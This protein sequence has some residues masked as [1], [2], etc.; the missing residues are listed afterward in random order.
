MGKQRPPRQKKRTETQTPKITARLLERPRT[1]RWW[2]GQDI[3]YPVPV[4][5]RPAI[6]D[7]L[8]AVLYED[9]LYWV[10]ANFDYT[11]VG[12]IT[13]DAVPATTS[14]PRWFGAAKIAASVIDWD[15]STRAVFV[16]TRHKASRSVVL[17]EGEPWRSGNLF[18]D[19]GAV[20]PLAANDRA[21]VVDCYGCLVDSSNRRGTIGEGVRI[22]SAPSLDSDGNIV[23]VVSTDDEVYVQ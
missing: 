21:V 5:A 9:C 4:Y 17:S 13:L 16:D 23:T 10:D 20:A 1:E 12:E 8:V 14:E 19:R 15:G 7:N 3:I 11:K 22:R 6:H 2:H 18:E